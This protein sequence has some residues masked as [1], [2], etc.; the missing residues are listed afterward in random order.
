MTKL[1]S[2][3]NVVTK[4]LAILVNFLRKNDDFSWKSR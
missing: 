4:I 3:V 2:E 1:W